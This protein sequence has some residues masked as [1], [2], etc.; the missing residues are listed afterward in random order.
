[1][2]HEIRVNRHVCVYCGGQGELVSDHVPPKLILSM[3]YPKSL[4]AVPV[5][6]ELPAHA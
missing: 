2:E 5:C 1:M 6:S 3:P 4:I